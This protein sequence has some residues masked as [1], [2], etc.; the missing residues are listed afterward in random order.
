MVLAEVL[1]AVVASGGQ[2]RVA[3][4]AEVVAAAVAA[5]LGPAAD[6]RSMGQVQDSLGLDLP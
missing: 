4:V 1:E 5:E 6:Q 2:E 3:V